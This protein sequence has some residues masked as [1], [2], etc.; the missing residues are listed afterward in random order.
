MTDCCHH[1]IA[2]GCGHVAP[3]AR[4]AAALATPFQPPGSSVGPR[5]RRAAV[6]S[7]EEPPLRPI[8]FGIRCSRGDADCVAGRVEAL[9]GS[10]VAR[11]RGTPGTAARGAGG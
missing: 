5:Y 3:A 10:L 8:G 1:P 6:T 4:H 9:P 11:R 2:D 7:R